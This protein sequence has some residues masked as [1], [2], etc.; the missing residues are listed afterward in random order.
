MDKGLLC[1]ILSL[2]S[3]ACLSHAKRPDAPQFVYKNLAGP[4]SQFLPPPKA[5]EASVSS[6][7][8]F[9]P[10][11]VLSASSGNS[12][13]QTRFVADG[14]IAFSIAI[15]CVE[16]SDLDRLR[17][18]VIAPSGAIAEPITVADGPFGI[19]GDTYSSRGLVFAFAEKGIW[20]LE[21]EV[22]EGEDSVKVFPFVA[23]PESVAVTVSA[24]NLN[25]MVGETVTLSA[26]VDRYW[27]SGEADAAADSKRMRKAPQRLG[28]GKGV[29]TVVLELRDP[30]GQVCLEIWSR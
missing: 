6:E 4:A 11:A 22:T 15:L 7:M 24:D 5:S 26:R 25:T 29:D 16:Q 8:R 28:L 27:E 2:L 10:P 20:R 13:Y 9:L 17:V 1:L 21:M 23:F 3:A 14:E 18:T 19:D 30:S 12:V